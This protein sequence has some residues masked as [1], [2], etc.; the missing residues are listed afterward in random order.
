MV[1]QKEY[2]RMFKEID[3]MIFTPKVN[4][5][6]EENEVDGIK[7]KEFKYEILKTADEVYEEYLNPQKPQQTEIETLKQR[8]AD[9]EN[10]ILQKELQESTN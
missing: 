2:E 7:E 9:M 4:Y 3:G 8:L 6:E 1:T 10:Y 5:V